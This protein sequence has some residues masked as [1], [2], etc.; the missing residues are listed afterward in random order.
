VY[1]DM[2]L[3]FDET[4]K[5]FAFGALHALSGSQVGL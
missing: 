2:P 3:G 4:G 1:K 5:E